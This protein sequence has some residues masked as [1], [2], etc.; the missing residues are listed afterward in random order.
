[1]N[2]NVKIAL[3]LGGIVVLGVGGFF[4]VRA[5]RKR[6]ATDSGNTFTPTNTSSGGGSSSSSSSS[7]SP[8]S[9]QSNGVG[10]GGGFSYSGFPLKRGGCGR[11]VY[12]LQKYLG[13]YQDGKFGRNTEKA[14]KNSQNLVSTTPIGWTAGYGKVSLSDYNQIANIPTSG[15]SSSSSGSSSSSSSVSST[16]QDAIS[17]GMADALDAQRERGKK[18]ADDLYEILSGGASQY[19]KFMAVKTKYQNK[20]K[21]TRKMAEIQWNENK[22]KYG[23]K[24]YRTSLKEKLGFYF[25]KANYLFPS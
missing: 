13:I 4:L 9:A 17:R 3:V 7:S 25:P 18:L 11:E 22:G 20:A 6:K 21:E 5:I 2:K 10:C 1:M 23:G 15:S 8:T 24:T 16:A 14:V 19:D 12:N